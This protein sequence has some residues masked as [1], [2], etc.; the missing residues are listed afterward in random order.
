VSDTL[1]DIGPILGQ[2]DEKTRRVMAERGERRQMPSGTKI[3]GISDVN[4]SLFFVLDGR[5]EVRIGQ[6]VALRTAGS[7]GP[8]DFFGEIS[9]FEPG[10]TSAEVST[11]EDS[12]LLEL[13][14]RVLDEMEEEE[15]EAAAAIYGALVRESAS[16][17]RAMDDELTDS[18]YWLLV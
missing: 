6:T 2:L 10:L 3:L 5:V 12:E 17:I 11:V 16:R 13:P 14:L 8:G 9:L 1:P 18:L 15:T 4:T 7:L